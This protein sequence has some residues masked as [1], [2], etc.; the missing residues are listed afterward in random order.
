MLKEAYPIK[1]ITGVNGVLVETTAVLER[2]RV[3]VHCYLTQDKCM[4]QGPAGEVTS[5]TEKFINFLPNLQLFSNERSLQ[6]KNCYG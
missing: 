6:I 3:R 1:E 4:F 5:F 2:P